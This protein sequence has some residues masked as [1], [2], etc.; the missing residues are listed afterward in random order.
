[1]RVHVR[2]NAYTLYVLMQPDRHRFGVQADRNWL[3][4]LKTLENRWFEVDTAYLFTNQLS[5][6]VPEREL[7][8][9]IPTSLLDTI[10]DDERESETAKYPEMLLAAIP[11]WLTRFPRSAFETG[12]LGWGFDKTAAAL[13][14][15]KYFPPNPGVDMAVAVEYIYSSRHSCRPVELLNAPK[16]IWLGLLMTR[17]AFVQMFPDLRHWRIRK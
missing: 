15:A 13:I 8:Y 3:D 16:E 17:E 7:G 10:E 9:R 1:M 5:L 11:D 4:T 2:P 6:K 12:S 14:A